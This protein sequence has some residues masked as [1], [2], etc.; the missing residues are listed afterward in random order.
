MTT[1]HIVYFIFILLNVLFLV[2]WRTSCEWKNYYGEKRHFPTKGH[3]LLLTVASLCPI[4]NICEFITLVI[5]YAVNRCDDAIVLK[6]N[7]F[8]KFWFDTDKE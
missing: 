1:A 4:L 7:K 2:W 8:N 6:K 5:I 3:M